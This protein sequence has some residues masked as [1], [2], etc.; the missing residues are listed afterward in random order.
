MQILLK[1]LEYDMFPIQSRI[2][3]DISPMK[4]STGLDGN[5]YIQ[6]KFHWQKGFIN[7]QSVKTKLQR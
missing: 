7:V 5:F 4:S 6:M 2:F 1:M 3:L